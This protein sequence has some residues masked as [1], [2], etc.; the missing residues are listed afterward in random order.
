MMKRVMSSET[1]VRVVDPEILTQHIAVTLS[2]GYFYVS[3]CRLQYSLL[4]SI[5]IKDRKSKSQIIIV[6]E[7]CSLR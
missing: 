1:S 4:N 2:E 5:Q 7:H 3:G 6:P